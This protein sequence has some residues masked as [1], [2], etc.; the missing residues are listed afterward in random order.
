MALL[1]AMLQEQEPMLAHIGADARAI[2]NHLDAERAQMRCWTYAGDLKEFRRLQRPGG[3][4]DFASSA[5]FMHHASLNRHDANSAPPFEDDLLHHCI[6]Q[7]TQ[8]RTMTRRFQE[9]FSSALA[10]AFFDRAA[11]VTDTALI[12]AI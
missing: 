3:Q 7:H 5:I 4:D 10:S 1:H 8:I 12:F 6:G 9:G 2:D 11:Q